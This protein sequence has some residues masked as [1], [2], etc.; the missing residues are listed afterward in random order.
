MATRTDDGSYNPIT[1]GDDYSGVLIGRKE[2]DWILGANSTF[3]YKDNLGNADWKEFSSKHE[4]QVY[5][6][7]YTNSYD[8]SLCT[9]YSSTD[10]LEHLFN[11]LMFK[12]EMPDIFIEWAKKEGYIENNRFEF[13]ERLA[14]ANSGM[15][16]KGTY[17]YKAADAIRKFGLVPQSKLP[18]AESF[19]DNINPELIPDEMYKLGKEFLQR[20]NINWH[21]VD[22]SEVANA[23]KY[24]PLVASVKYADG[25]GI[26]KPEGK[27]NHAITV[28]DKDPNY[29]E[30][31]DSYWRQYKK[32]GL[33]YVDDFLQF[34]I[35]FNY[36]NMEVNDFIK[37]ND[38]RLIRNISNGAYAVIYGGNFLKISQDR[39]GLF[40]VDRLARMI[41]EQGVVSIT[42]K[43]WA[44][45]DYKDLK[46]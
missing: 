26:L 1:I 31:D 30:I 22:K 37:K 19:Y 25:D 16:P 45:L 43:E 17:F 13:S 41:E 35:T 2:T 36:N 28:I 12:G 14:G 38:T 40:T 21:W 15:T 23:I 10:V 42:D 34:Y 20:V 9:Q 18:L 11:V 7:G 39:A 8:T 5:N 4:I 3:Q 46:F 27:H 33:D 6:P 24:S 32:Y 44:M 29:Y